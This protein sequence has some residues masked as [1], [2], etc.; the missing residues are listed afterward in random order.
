MKSL[1]LRWLICL[2]VV[3]LFAGPAVVMAVDA[4][5]VGSEQIID[6][7]IKPWDIANGAVNSPKI[8]DGSI[9]NADVAPGAAIAASKINRT[10]LNADLL[11]GLN[12]SAFALGGHNHDWAYV[13]KPQAT[14]EQ[15]AMLKW[16][17]VGNN[18]PVGDGPDGIAFDGTYI[19]VA[20]NN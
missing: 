6:L 17:E 3:A 18:F 8:A 15:I 11:D 1:I 16:Y 7:S 19:W 9:T 14:A 13:K 20:N 10:G 12:S 2:V 4:N 5:T